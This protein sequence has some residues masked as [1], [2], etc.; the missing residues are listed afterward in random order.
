MENQINVSVVIA[1]YN[2]EKYLDYCVESII[3]QTYQDFEVILVNDGSKDSSET[4]IDK[5][6]SLYPGKFIKINKENGGLSSARN[7]AFPH[8]R[9]KYITFLDADD[10]YD[11]K[12]LELLV[13]KAES[14][15]L[16]MVCS[17]QNKVTMDGTILNIISYKLKNGTTLQRRLNISGKLYK[18]D[19]VRKFDMKFPIGKTYE[20]NSFNMQ[21]FF[22]SP[23]VGFIDYEGYNQVV[24]E[25]SIT[26][27]P[28]DSSRLPFDEWEMCAKKIKNSGV[29]GVDIE[30]FDFTY[31]SFLTYFLMVRNRKRE[32]LS[33]DNKKQSMDSVYEIT[34]VF[35]KIVNENFVGYRKNKYLNIF[36]NKELPLSQKIGTLAFYTFCRMHKLKLLVKIVYSIA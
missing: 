1:V 29:P 30:L 11:K 22:L 12:Y 20:D 21:A 34:S 7:I 23:K 36:K 24:H 15:N 9:G 6:C 3:S 8:V 28:I 27:K 26:S 32:Y 5:Y 17:G 16:D 14:E 35:E 31:V 4:I 18:M 33:N 19:Y 25:G 2:M 13:T 10:Y